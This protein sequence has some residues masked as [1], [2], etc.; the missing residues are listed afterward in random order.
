MTSIRRRFDRV[1]ERFRALPPPDTLVSL[2]DVYQ[3]VIKLAAQPLDP[4]LVIDLSEHPVM[5]QLPP[6]CQMELGY[7]MALMRF[8]V[9][10]HEAGEV[11]NATA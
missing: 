2:R 5:G 1:G 3:I 4:R 9:A 6:K 7:A 10:L 11:A 8:M